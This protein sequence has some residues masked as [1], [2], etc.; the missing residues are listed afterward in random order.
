MNANETIVMDA[1]VKASDFQ[2][3]D[4][5]FT[6]DVWRNGLLDESTITKAQFGGYVIQI[7]KKGYIKS[8]NDYDPTWKNGFQLTLKGAAYAG[9][10]LNYETT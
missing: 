8:L 2:G 1:L 9:V 3:H 4:F 10:E 7:I 6:D 5:G